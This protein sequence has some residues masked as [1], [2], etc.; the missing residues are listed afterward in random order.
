M[1]S[2]GMTGVFSILAGIGTANT[3]IG[4]ANKSYS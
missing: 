1:T 3:G 2:L 4:T